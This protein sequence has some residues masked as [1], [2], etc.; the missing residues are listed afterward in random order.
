MFTSLGMLQ[1]CCFCFVGISCMYCSCTDYNPACVSLY[2][3]W[4]VWVYACTSA[5]SILGS[6]IRSQCYR[7]CTL[8]FGFW[9]HVQPNGWQ[10]VFLHTK[11]SL[12][13]SQDCGSIFYMGFFKFLYQMA[14]KSPNNKEK[15]FGGSFIA[16]FS[17]RYSVPSVMKRVK[18]MPFLNSQQS[19][20]RTFMK[21]INI[22]DKVVEDMQMLL[23]FST[24]CNILH[25]YYYCK[26]IK[27]TG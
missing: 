1:M 2:Y 24:S 3:L 16:F 27:H 22:T 23:A 20:I 7:A 21:T 10:Y 12:P 18:I 6:L 9:V 26:P 15:C 19:T 25:I 8:G 11:K 5:S 13:L 4:F 17:W 14:R